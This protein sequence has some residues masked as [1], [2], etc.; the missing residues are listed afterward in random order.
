MVA[1]LL[2][3]RLA[4]PGRVL[5]LLDLR[6]PKP[7]PPPGDEAGYGGFGGEEEI[8]VGSVSDPEVLAEALRDVDAIVHLGGQSRESDPRDI[9]ESNM[10]GTY[11]LLE[12]ARAAGVRRIILASSNHAA[13]FCARGDHP[14]PADVPGRPD[15]LYG[16]SKVAAEACGRLYADR[17]GVDVLCLRIGTWFP[18]PPDLRA[19]ALWLSPDDGARLIEACLSAPDPGYRII[20]G[21]SHNTRRWMSLSEGEAIGYYPQDDAEQ[22]ADKLIGAFGEPDFVHDPVL[23]RVGGKWCEIPLGEPF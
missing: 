21:I 14:L 6:E 8:V 4:K 17:F 23:T 10:Y 7:L 12:A 3:S 13:G 1:T 18:T 2:R 9:I 5:R 22:Y 16:W 19:L 15:T 11:N 20:W